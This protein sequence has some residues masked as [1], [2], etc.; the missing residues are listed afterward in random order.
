MI[1][2]KLVKK[3]KEQTPVAAT[4]PTTTVNAAPTT[5]QAKP[6][7]ATSTKPQTFG[8]LLKILQATRKQ[9][10]L[11]AVKD[12]ATKNAVDAAL[13]LFPGIAA[14]KTIYDGAKQIYK[15]GDAQK[16]NSVIDKINV[17]DQWAKIADDS[18]EEQFLKY[19]IDNITKIAQTNP[20]AVV[21]DRYADTEFQNYL[22]K[23]YGNRSMVK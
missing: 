17:D 8:E 16:T 4:A 10:K 21:P 5:T 23:A 11:D 13:G 19:M 12:V 14:A 6:Q 2:V 20:M 15:A 22:K 3:L 1:K 7:T 9:I 18:V